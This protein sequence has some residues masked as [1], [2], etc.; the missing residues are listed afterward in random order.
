[1]TTVLATAAAGFTPLGFYAAMLAW[2][3]VVSYRLA[4]G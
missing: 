4:T 2:F 1:V 3:F